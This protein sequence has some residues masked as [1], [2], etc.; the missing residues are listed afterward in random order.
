MLQDNVY[1]RNTAIGRIDPFIL[2]VLFIIEG[3][4]VI[5]VV[6]GN[7]RRLS[8]RKADIGLYGGFDDSG[9]Q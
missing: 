7:L 2:H 9:L 4:V 3:I 5:F 6:I 8:G 1:L